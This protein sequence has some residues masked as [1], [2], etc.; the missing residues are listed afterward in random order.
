MTTQSKS[1]SV[2]RPP[3]LSVSFSNCPFPD[4]PADGAEAEEMKGITTPHC[5]SIRLPTSLSV[6]PLLGMEIC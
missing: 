5:V 4:A 3:A 1:L 2:G 6:S